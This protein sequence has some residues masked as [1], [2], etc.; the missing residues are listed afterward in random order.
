LGGWLGFDSNL[1]RHL[2]GQLDEVAVYATALSPARIAAHYQAAASIEIVQQPEDAWAQPGQ[3]ASFTVTAQA[4][5]AQ[6]PLTYGWKRNGNVIP[7]ATN[8]TYT[9]GSLGT[10]DNGAQF[11]CDV[12]AGSLTEESKTVFLTIVN[13]NT[14]YAQAVLADQPILYYR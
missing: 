13:T 4:L 14:P 2:N 12:T 3:T 8:A 1:H 7:D 9:T 5:G 11:R 6:G 10:A